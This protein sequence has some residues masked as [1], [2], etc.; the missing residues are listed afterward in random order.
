MALKDPKSFEWKVLYAV[1]GGLDAAQWIID[2][3]VGPG[4]VINE[5]LDPIIGIC[6]GIFFQLSGVSMTQRISRL[7]SLVGGCFAEMFSVS[8]APAWIIDIWYIHSSVKQEWA[9][10][11]ASIAEADDDEVPAN[12]MIEG[13]MMRK[14]PVIKPSNQGKVRLP[15]GG[16]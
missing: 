11:Q 6:I 4:E 5:V 13:K 2:A 7:L 3:F 16:I 12:R 15:N 14:P 10:Q 9:M 8:V 1:S